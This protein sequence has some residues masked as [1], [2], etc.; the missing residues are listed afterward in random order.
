MDPDRQESCASDYSQASTSW[1]AVLEL[2]RQ[3]PEAEGEPMIDVVYDEPEAGYEDIAAYLADTGLLETAA[4]RV[5]AEYALPGPVTFRA[6]MCEEDNA[7]YDASVPEV[8]LCYEHA[9]GH[10][11]RYLADLTAEGGEEEAN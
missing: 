1:D 9:Q 7:F 6:G 11:D 4:A 2:H 10:F 5:E 8:V 3:A